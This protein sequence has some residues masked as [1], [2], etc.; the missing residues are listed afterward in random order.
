MESGKG[1]K[2]FL[3]D[4]FV[5]IS[6]SEEWSVDKLGAGQKEHNIKCEIVT[7]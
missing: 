7:I 3:N 6:D 2:L 1:H 5:R 4:V